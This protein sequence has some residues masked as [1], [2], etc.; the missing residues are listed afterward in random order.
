MDPACQPPSVPS[1]NSAA[2]LLSP[3]SH[4]PRRSCWCCATPSQTLAQNRCPKR[5]AC[6]ARLF[7]RARHSHAASPQAPT[8]VTCHAAQLVVSSRYPTWSA[9]KLRPNTTTILTSLPFELPAHRH[10]HRARLGC[11]ISRWHPRQWPTDKTPAVPTTLSERTYKEVVTSCPHHPIG[12]VF[13]TVSCRRLPLFFL[14]Q[15]AGD[16]SRHRC[17]FLPSR[18]RGTIRTR[19]SSLSCRYHTSLT[20]A[21]HRPRC[22]AAEA[23]LLLSHHA[24][25]SFPLFGGLVHS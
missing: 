24:G 14:S 22:A 16:N 9:D 23:T 19:R 13:F 20:G 11:L 12:H 25:P 15:L 2:P 1:P 5:I 6:L 8:I 21:V 3:T 10:P 7:G 17:F 18:S 4:V